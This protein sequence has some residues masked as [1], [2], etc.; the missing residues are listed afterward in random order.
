VVVGKPA[1]IPSLGTRQLAI[2]AITRRIWRKCSGFFVR[3]D[4]E[5]RRHAR[6]TSVRLK[7][8]LR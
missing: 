4:R 8:S 2:L 5:T 6:Y 1:K 3:S 7:H